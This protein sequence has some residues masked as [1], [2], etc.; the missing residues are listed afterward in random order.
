M[1]DTASNTVAASVPVGSSVKIAVSPDGKHAYVTHDL[2][3]LSVIDTASNKVVATV[4]V[5]KEP[6]GLALTPDGKYAYVVN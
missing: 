4:D 6:G 2:N 3:S 5:G 1:I